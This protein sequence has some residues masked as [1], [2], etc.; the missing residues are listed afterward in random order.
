MS[1]QYELANYDRVL[2]FVGERIAHATNR[3]GSDEDQIRWTEVDVYRTNGGHYVL[4]KIG[5]SRVYHAGPKMCAG[6]TGKKTTGRQIGYWDPERIVDLAPCPVC[7]PGSFADH[8]VVV[9]EQD[10]GVTFTS[11]TAAGVVESAHNQDSD[12][13]TYL[14]RVAERALAEASEVDEQIRDAYRVETIA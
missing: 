10:R 14:T 2:R 8:Q 7:R 6:T 5:K 11:K 1:Q 13:V 4:H 9:V 3:R 12:G